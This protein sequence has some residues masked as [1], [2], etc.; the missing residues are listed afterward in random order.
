VSHVAA[1]IR[2]RLLLAAVAAGVVLAVLVLAAIVL[3]G[4]LTGAAADTSGD[5]GAVY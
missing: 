3:V 5:Y 4:A 1:A 2:S